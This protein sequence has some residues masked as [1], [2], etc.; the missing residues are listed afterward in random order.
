VV[1]AQAG[2]NRLRPVVLAQAGRNRLRLVV[3]AQAGRNQLRPY[4]GIIP[5]LF[6][7]VHY[8]VLFAIEPMLGAGRT[9]A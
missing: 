6:L 7:K 8:Y 1:L 4:G 5:I 9:R 2:R 3:L